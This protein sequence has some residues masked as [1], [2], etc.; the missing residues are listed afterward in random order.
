L[1]L[2]TS[3]DVELKLV[4]VQDVSMKSSLPFIKEELSLEQ[5]VLRG[6]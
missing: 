1:F 4:F 2:L 6:T 3:P 5:V